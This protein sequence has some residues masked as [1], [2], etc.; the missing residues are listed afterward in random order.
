MRESYAPR[1]RLVLIKSP[2]VR[3]QAARRRAL[4]AAGVLALAVL[5]GVIGAMARPHGEP[6]GRP[7]TGPF[8]YF[9]SE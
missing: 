7:H 4:T 1:G 5:S 9:P 2:N 6:L 8:S 3:Q